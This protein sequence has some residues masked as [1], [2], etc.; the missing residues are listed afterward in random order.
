MEHLVQLRGILHKG[1][2]L[3][4]LT[5]IEVAEKLRVSKQTVY[6]LINDGEL[7]AYTFGDKAF[8]VLDS[9]LDEFIKSRVFK[10]ENV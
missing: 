9:D 10:V 7:L 3:D 5:V 2:I 1:N 8:R 6:R 4:Y